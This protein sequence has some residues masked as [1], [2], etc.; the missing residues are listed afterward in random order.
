MDTLSSLGNTWSLWETQ[1]PRPH[2]QMLDENVILHKTHREFLRFT[3]GYEAQPRICKCGPNWEVWIQISEPCLY[4]K[5]LQY[6]GHP[7]APRQGVEVLESLKSGGEDEAPSSSYNIWLV[8]WIT[9]NRLLPRQV[10]SV[11]HEEKMNSWPSTLRVS[12]R[13][14]F[15]DILSM[16]LLLFGLP[17]CLSW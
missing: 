17:L 3:E 7:E 10:L 1:T 11:S 2:S 8:Y 14:R 9:N 12:W 4:P 6:E 5:F 13:S 16:F 15:L